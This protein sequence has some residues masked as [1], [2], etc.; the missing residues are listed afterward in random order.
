MKTSVGFPKITLS[1]ALFACSSVLLARDLGVVG[2]V[3]PIA[4]Q[5]M[6]QT[7]EQRLTALEASGELTRL[8]DDAK[9]RYQAYV[10]RPE[11]VQLPRATKNHTYYVDPSL[12]VPYD[13]K[14]HEG[15]I[16]HPAGTTVN[17]LDYMTLSKQL[18]FFD[19]DDP[20]QVEWARAM[21]ESNSVHM[22]PILTNGPVLALMKEWQVRL[23][24]DQQ[25][26]LIERFHIQRVPV[27]VTQDG[28][29]LTVVEYG[30][31]AQK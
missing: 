6:L 14:D 23:Y 22:K 11:G 12:T 27:I 31:S 20:V 21:V 4:E 9:A 30:L 2:P 13:I 5:D 19:G 18:L 3:Y 15:R 7:I 10:E 25:G 8:E 24:F 16:I 1:V 28:T 17:P 29:R 26:M